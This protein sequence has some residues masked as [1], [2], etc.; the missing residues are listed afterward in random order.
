MNGQYKVPLYFDNE[1]FDSIEY[2]EPI[3]ADDW[4][5][6]QRDAMEVI[7]GESYSDIHVGVDMF[8]HIAI[9]VRSE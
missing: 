6:I 2:S 5:Q 4:Q 7:D 8:S 3:T 9:F 1:Y